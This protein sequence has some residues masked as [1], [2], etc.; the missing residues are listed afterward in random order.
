MPVNE[1]FT[2]LPSPTPNQVLWYSLPS[3]S[4][5]PFKKGGAIFLSRDL[6]G[7]KGDRAALQRKLY[8]VSK[9]KTFRNKAERLSGSWIT[10]FQRAW[11]QLICISACHP[12]Q[13][14]MVKRCQLRKVYYILHL[15]S[16]TEASWMKDTEQTLLWKIYPLIFVHRNAIIFKKLSQP[17]VHSWWENYHY[18]YY[19]FRRLLN[20]P[21]FRR[22]RMNF[23]N[24]TLHWTK[25]SSPHL[26]G[27]SCF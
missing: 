15:L 10:I 1:T 21:Q 14:M 2:S 17:S 11:T 16:V 23:F 9:K 19:Q 20:Y 5:R 24:V 22:L 3:S 12:R 25:G 8:P 6:R 4:L 13:M 18:H 26:T 7:R 27:Y